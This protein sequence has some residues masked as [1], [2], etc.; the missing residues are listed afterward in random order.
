MFWYAS[1]GVEYATR[2]RLPPLPCG[3]ELPPGRVPAVP[4]VPAPDVSFFFEQPR[5][6]IASTMTKG[7]ASQRCTDVEPVMDLCTVSPRRLRQAVC[8]RRS[9]VGG[10]LL[11]PCSTVVR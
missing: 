5:A 7:M 2:F 1:C 6:S 4:P 3:L 9:N 8:E 10:W 11:D